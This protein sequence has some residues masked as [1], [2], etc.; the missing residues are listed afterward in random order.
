MRIFLKTIAAV[1]ALLAAVA[2]VS[3]SCSATAPQPSGTR[4]PASS[5]TA[6]PEPA[7]IWPLL[8]L[9]ARGADA[10]RIRVVSVKVENATGARPQ[11]GLSS[12]DV[13]YETITEG[14][15][16]RYDAIFHSTAP[17][18]V[19]PVRSARLS[20]IYLPN[21]Y[22][23]L[24]ARI[25]A[26]F[27]VE[28]RLKQAHVQDMNEFGNPAPY[29]RTNDRRS[30]HNLYVSVPAVR[31]AAVKRGF[32]S[33]EDPPALAFGDAPGSGGT[34]GTVVEI[35][36]SQVNRVRWTWSPQA[37]RYVRELNGS[38]QGD[39]ATGR[40][41]EASNVVVLFAR[42]VLGRALD[43]AGNR[44]YDVQ[45]AGTGKVV[46]FRGGRRYDGTWA[47]GTTDPPVLT[48]SDGSQLKLEPGRTWFQV[49]PTGAS[50]T[51]R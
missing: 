27:D 37:K 36:F 25:G 33:A 19:G 47:A 40:P 42:T 6:T 10:V 14:G 21:Q 24:L 4:P 3:C 17:R 51:S 8:G 5:P 34:T 12:A 41:Y 7:V 20:D 2:L 26:D 39:A 29:F 35:P 49:V 15:I 1:I 11:T 30:P 22:H 18:K 48:A 43:P 28:N 38:R 45:L 9:P 13:V 50:I 46:V 16:T 23:A 44:T 32:P 31:K